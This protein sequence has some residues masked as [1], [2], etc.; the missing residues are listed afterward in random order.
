[1]GNSLGLVIPKKEVERHKIA[2]GDVVEL[3]VEKKANIRELFGTLKFREETQ[4]LKE[5]ARKGWGG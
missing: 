5:E 2:E 1:M 3:E 4:E